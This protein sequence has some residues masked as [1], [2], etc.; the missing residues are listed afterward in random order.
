MHRCY[1]QKSE[2]HRTHLEDRSILSDHTYLGQ[3]C[4][5]FFSHPLGCQKKIQGALLDTNI[6]GSK[7]GAVHQQGDFKPKVVKS[8]T[9]SL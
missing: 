3:L 1:F 2:P 9:V 7:E 4:S 6:T 5:A 8:V